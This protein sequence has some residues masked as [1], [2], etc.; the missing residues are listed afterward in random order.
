MFFAR[1]ADWID[2]INAAAGRLAS[3]CCLF[4]IAVE[5]A[6]VVMRYVFGVGS[7]AAQES[8][9]YVASA[10]FMLAAAWTLQIGGHVRVDIIYQPAAP[11]SRAIIDLVGSLLF[12]LPFAIVL[13]L[14]S[15][16]YVEHSWAIL[17]RSRETSGLPFT[18]L[19]KTLIPLF[20]VLLGL[21]GIAQIIRAVIVLTGRPVQAHR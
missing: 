11:C 1:I 12:L 4:V 18:Y 20:A 13:A 7:I 14:V 8:V 21:Q 9:L 19:M 10:L 2:C 3:W 5:F 15:L 16:P 6:V 17:E